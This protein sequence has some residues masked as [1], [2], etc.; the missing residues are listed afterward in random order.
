MFK[1]LNINYYQSSYRYYLGVNLTQEQIKSKIYVQGKEQ[2]GLG[3]RKYSKIKGWLLTWIGIS[4]AFTNIDQT[5]IYLNKK[6]FC[7]ACYRLAHFTNAQQAYEQQ[8]G[9]ENL[10]TILSIFNRIFKPNARILDL[11]VNMIQQF[12]PNHLVF[13]ES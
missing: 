6:S 1:N 12:N 8:S 5:T 11:S 13:S 9:R 7:L 3:M 2:A 10:P 4:V